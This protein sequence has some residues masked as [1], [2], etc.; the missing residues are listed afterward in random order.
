MALRTVAANLD[1]RGDFET[2]DWRFRGTECD[3]RLPVCM[4]RGVPGMVV[5]RLCTQRWLGRLTGRGACL[6]PWRKDFRG[7]VGAHLLWVAKCP[8]VASV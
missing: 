4:L 3:M 1:G 8:V 2:R 5:A 6:L 7:I